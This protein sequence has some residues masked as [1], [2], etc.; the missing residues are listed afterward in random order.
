MEFDDIAVVRQLT[1]D[2]TLSEHCLNLV[3]LRNVCLL[4]LFK[5]KLS[6]VP[7]GQIDLSICSTA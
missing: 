3:I 1:A 2:I 7:T 4:K 6:I 5:G